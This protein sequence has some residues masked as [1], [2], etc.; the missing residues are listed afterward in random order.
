MPLCQHL[1]WTTTKNHQQNPSN[2]AF[3]TVLSAASPSGRYVVAIEL[4][5]GHM[6]C[7]FLGRET[8][9]KGFWQRTDAT[10]MAAYNSQGTMLLPAGFWQAPVQ[11]CLDSAC[12]HHGSCSLEPLVYTCISREISTLYQKNP[13]NK[14]RLSEIED[15]L[16]FLLS[17]G[18]GCPVSLD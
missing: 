10:L 6:S 3:N 5:A 4:S 11:P 8:V 9:T 7:V 13:K 12:H 18:G 15:H 16:F 2:S 1:R 17:E 14:I